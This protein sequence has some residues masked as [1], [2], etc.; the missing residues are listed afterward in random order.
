MALRTL[1]VT[2]AQARVAERVAPDAMRRRADAGGTVL[3]STHEL[4]VAAQGA[5]D[6]VLLASGRVL[7]SGTLAST[8][9]DGLLSRLFAVSAR[10]A[11]GPSGR[12]VVSLGPPGPE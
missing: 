11:A 7:A 2:L 5:D 1:P 4:D 9:T 8:L 6:A 3:F 12:P 10:V